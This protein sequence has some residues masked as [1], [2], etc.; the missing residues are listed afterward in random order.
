[1]QDQICNK[2][3]KDGHVTGLHANVHAVTFCGHLAKHPSIPLKF[4]MTILDKIIEKKRERISSARYKTSLSDLKS[5]IRDIGSSRDFAAAI[6]R[7]PQGI[8]LIAEVKKASPSRGLIRKDFDHRAIASIYEQKEVSAVS[9]ITEEDFFQGRLGFLEEVR[10]IVSMPVLRKDFIVDEYQI[11]E[12]RAAGAD[13]LLLICA[14]LEPNQAS[15]YLRLSIELGIGVLFEVHE[16]AELETAVRIG[17]P[18]IG[19][20]NRSLK[21]LRVD[22]DTTFKLRPEVPA[23]FVVVSESGIG[24]R[25]EVL[26]LEEAG[27]D[28][29]LVGTSFMEAPDIGLKIDLLMR[30]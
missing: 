20:N 28:A 21:T 8:R 10:G 12:S 27:I 17:A 22:L 16:K 4:G 24:S 14:A 6:K 2:K 13:A 1:M 19:I 29:M 9:V 25:K 30:D 11:Y 3:P 26:R 5:K 7:G 23:G 15:D 18:V